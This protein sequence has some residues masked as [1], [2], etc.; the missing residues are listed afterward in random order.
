MLMLN[1]KIKIYK[2]IFLEPK[3]FVIMYI[4]VVHCCLS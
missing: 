2:F 3:S 1:F 4:Y